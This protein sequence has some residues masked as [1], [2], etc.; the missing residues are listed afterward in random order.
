MRHCKLGDLQL[1]DRT[2]AVP[3]ETALEP[4]DG[5]SAGFPFDHVPVEGRTLSLLRSSGT[6]RAVRAPP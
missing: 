3:L 6:T 5:Q 1:Q 2:G 4:F